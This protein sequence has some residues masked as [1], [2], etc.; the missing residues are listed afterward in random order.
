MRLIK[1]I[2]CKFFVIILKL[3]ASLRKPSSACV[4]FGAVNGSSFADNSRYV[5]EWILAHR[6]NWRPV[7]ITRNRKVYDDLHQKSKPV[8]LMLS[9][10]GLQCLSHARI[11][12]YT[13]SLRDLAF[14]AGMIPDAIKLIALRHGKSLK[15]VRFARR[16]HKMSEYENSERLREA[17]LI[18]YAISTSEFVSDIQEECL[19]I[20][21]QKHVITGFPRN[22]YML[23]PTREMQMSWQEYVKGKS[24]KKII[25]YGPSWRH[26]RKATVFFPFTDFNI[27]K[28]KSLLE[29]NNILLLLRPHPNDLR[30]YR[31]LGISLSSLAQKTDNIRLASHDYFPDA[32]AIL[33]FID[34]LISDYSALYHDFL[35]M[36]RPLIFIPYDYEDFNEQNGFLYDYY[37]NLPGPAVSLFQDLCIHIEEICQ[38]KDPYAEKRRKLADKVHTYKDA[39]SCARVVRL[40]EGLMMEKQ[41]Y[42][43]K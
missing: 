22:D 4:L 30:Q 6:P 20:G 13:H 16:Q 39:G 40:I 8:A 37:Q 23:N 32:H 35:L 29:Q 3:M 17:R 11:G 10:R 41:V 36:D 38:G 27:E 12:V 33:P 31:E 7:W 9:W 24:Y 1:M 5:Y 14:F 2:A 28:L 26:G 19:R 18:H 15:R 42:G 43:K 21:R 25:L 34:V